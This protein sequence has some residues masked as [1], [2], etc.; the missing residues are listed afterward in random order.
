MKGQKWDNVFLSILFQC[1]STACTD[2][3]PAH[4]LLS[5]YTVVSSLSLFLNLTLSYLC[6]LTIIWVCDVLFF[7]KIYFC[8]FVLSTFLIFNFFSCYL[9]SMVSSSTS[10]RQK[11]IYSQHDCKIHTFPLFMKSQICIFWMSH[12]G[13]QRVRNDW[14]DLAHTCMILSRVTGRRWKLG[15][16]GVPRRRWRVDNVK[17]MIYFILFRTG[18][19]HGGT[20]SFSS[21]WEIH[22]QF[23]L[24]WHTSL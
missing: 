23:F 19:R 2:T 12:V 8:R 6:L 22:H 7:W 15:V 16:S 17:Q 13:L 11:H 5:V 1:H 10:L 4:S 9:L 20:N 3:I 14:R 21:K 18:I 24:F